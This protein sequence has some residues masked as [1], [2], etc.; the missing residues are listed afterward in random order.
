MKFAVKQVVKKSKISG[1]TIIESI[2]VIIAVIIISFILA[3][4]Y[5]RNAEI[6]PPGSSKSAAPAP[7]SNVAP[8]TNP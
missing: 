8:E 6:P 2:F 1:F 5:L 7:E 3:G 4:L